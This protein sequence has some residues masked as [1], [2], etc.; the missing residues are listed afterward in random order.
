MER[1]NENDDMK[2]FIGHSKKIQYN[3]SLQQRQRDPLVCECQISF[4]LIST[5]GWPRKHVQPMP[6]LRFK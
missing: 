3:K 4:A 1:I 5:I 2:P 6:V